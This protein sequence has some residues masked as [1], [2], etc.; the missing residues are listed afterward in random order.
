M[1]FLPSK[2]QKCLFGIYIIKNNIDSRVYIGEC[3]NF[4]KRYSRHLSSLRRN[5]HCNIKLQNF[6]N[7]YGIECLE[8]DIIEVASENLIDLEISYIQQYNSIESGFNIILDSRTMQHVTKEQRVLGRTRSRGYKLSEQSRKNISEGR[9]RY[10]QENPNTKRC[11]WTEERKEQRRKYIKEHPEKYANR[12]P[13]SGNKINHRRG[14]E[15]LNTN[16]TEE[17]VLNIKKDI[18][19]NNLPKR[20]VIAKYPITNSQ[21]HSIRQNKTWKHVIIQ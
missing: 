13:S 6:V 10:Y 2:E 16:L 12:K 18:Y 20:E 17:I 9:K 3:N 8:F 1:K 5:V 15:Q 14:S 11:K 19:L 4:Y 21:Y 7:K